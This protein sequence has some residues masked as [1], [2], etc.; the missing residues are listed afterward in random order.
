M[1]NETYLSLVNAYYDTIKPPSKKIKANMK[2][3]RKLLKDK[4]DYTD[5]QYKTE[6]AKV[7]KELFEVIGKENLTKIFKA[8]I[9]KIYEIK[10]RPLNVDL[11][12][13]DGLSI[14]K[15]YNSIYS[16]LTE[17]EKKQV[18]SKTNK[19]VYKVFN[20]EEYKEAKKDRLY[21]EIKDQ[22]MQSLDPEHKK[23]VL[24]PSK[25]K[26]VIIKSQ[27]QN[28]TF[29]LPAAF[30]QQKTEN[31][32]QRLRTLYN[33]IIRENII[34]DD[35]DNKIDLTYDG[36]GTE[37][38]D[39]S[40]LEGGFKKHYDN[41]NKTYRD[42]IRLKET[43]QKDYNISDLDRKYYVEKYKE[44]IKAKNDLMDAYK[45][46]G[47]IELREFIKL[48]RE[49]NKKLKER[50]KAKQKEK[51]RPK[52]N[53][54]D[55]IMQNPDE[56]KEE[57]DDNDDDGELDP[58]EVK[59]LLPY[60]KKNKLIR[61]E[62]LRDK[63]FK[64]KDFE[65]LIRNRARCFVFGP[66]A[67]E[68]AIKNNANMPLDDND[69][70]PEQQQQEPPPQPEPEAKEEQKPENNNEE[71]EDEIMNVEEN[72]IDKKQPEPEQEQEQETKP[73]ESK[74]EIK[75]PD[76]KPKEISDT[77]QS[78]KIEFK[79]KVPKNYDE[80]PI[81]EKKDVL[82]KYN[83]CL[84]QF[85][86]LH[87]NGRD[88]EKINFDNKT[89]TT[90]IKEN[91]NLIGFNNS[92]IKGIDSISK[93][94]TYFNKLIAISAYCEEEI[95][96]L[97]DEIDEISKQ[98]LPAPA[99]S[100]DEED[101]E[102]DDDEHNEKEAEV[103]PSPPVVLQPERGIKSPSPVALQHEE[104]KEVKQDLDTAPPKPEQLKAVA[105]FEQ[106]GEQPQQ[107]Q[108]FNFSI[109]NN[110]ELDKGDNQIVEQQ[111]RNDIYNKL[112]KQH[113]DGLFLY[114]IMVAYQKDRTNFAKK[115]FN[116][117]IRNPENNKQLNPDEYIELAN[118]YKDAFVNLGK[119]MNYII[120]PKRSLQT[121]EEKEAEMQNY[122]IEYYDEFNKICNI[123]KKFRDSITS[124][125]TYIKEF[126]TTTSGK[127]LKGFKHLKI[128]PIMKGGP[129][130]IKGFAEALKEKQN[131][132]KSINK[133][134][135]CLVGGRILTLNEL[136]QIIDRIK[137]QK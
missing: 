5:D 27:N 86:K 55:D 82:E 72:N 43:Q 111:I 104:T 132:N 63:L 107:K 37:I 98:P 31:P 88:E 76:A 84:D 121:P 131:E 15:I 35:I 42:L 36:E 41:F 115:W 69:T 34:R 29:K 114:E 77:P 95:K 52:D 129:P 75:P 9:K 97:R 45:D 78:K 17:E 106:T 6:Y 64:N 54:G 13:Y 21:N 93:Q 120:N 33:T 90:Q 85:M 10:K 39:L 124:S 62:S 18:L 66:R 16:T 26:P 125:E 50:Y 133:N 32:E 94:D 25:Q 12:K 137:K 7:M 61:Y 28:Q 44:Y 20:K 89:I 117:V 80:M 8:K 60:I 134:N 130:K 135:S 71:A 51:E 101:E 4:E 91:N 128:N 112:I 30:Y 110:D 59:N 67:V 105:E 108:G 100:Q 92:E 2:K 96:K 113:E 103:K 24:N 116:G 74:A 3:Y 46:C 87:C 68:R 47:I 119:K 23:E 65:R 109:L 123:F 38:M 102:E 22:I 1:I 118:K 73:P 19:K 53:E 11:D 57:E 58:E 56:A 79:Y 49:I 122:N 136:D 126:G 81:N 48:H 83:K 99:K 70:K 14:E 127:G 40:I